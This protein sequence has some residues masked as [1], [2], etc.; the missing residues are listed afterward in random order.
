MSS[1]PYGRHLV[2]VADINLKNMQIED[3][4]LEINEIPLNAL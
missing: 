3:V 4:T 2:S 1:P